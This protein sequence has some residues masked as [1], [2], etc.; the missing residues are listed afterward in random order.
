M[1]TFFLQTFQYGAAKLLIMQGPGL[2]LI[3]S[4]RAV[5]LIG[6]IHDRH[7]S[8]LGRCCSFCVDAHRFYRWRDAQSSFVKT[9]PNSTLA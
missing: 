7:H 4:Q 9:N 1:L 2:S 5:S 6:S 8:Y 3:G